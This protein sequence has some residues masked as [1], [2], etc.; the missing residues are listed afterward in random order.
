MYSCPFTDLTGKRPVRSADAHSLLWEVKV[1]LSRG[2]SSGSGR[3]GS[4]GGVG[5]REALE[6]TERQVGGGVL[7]VD[8][9]PCLK[10]SRCPYAVAR[11]R[12]GNLRTR[13]WVKRGIPW[14]Y[15]RERARRKVER[16]GEPKLR[17]W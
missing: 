15:P 11:E 7:R 16:E 4:G 3:L 14:M 8:A 9:T 1:K 17:W 13:V 10:V 6:A 2:A 5:V 12:G